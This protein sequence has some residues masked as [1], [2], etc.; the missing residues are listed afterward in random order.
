MDAARGH[1][2]LRHLFPGMVV[3]LAIVATGCGEDPAQG[4]D[5]VVTSAQRDG[6]VVTLS[7]ST[8]HVVAGDPIKL[9]VD[10]LNAGL[11]IVSWQ[12][13][14]CELLN[15][16]GIEGRQIT[17]P[18]D[19]R[20]WP[21]G[22]GLA[23]WSATTGGVALAGIQL[24]SSQD[25][26]LAAC[27]ADLRYEDIGP[28]E[29]ISADAVWSGQSTDGVPAPPG[30]YQLVYAFPFIG[31]VPAAQLGGATPPV[32]PIGV[33]LPIVL[34]GTAFSGLPSTLAIDAALGDPRVAA[35]SDAHLP[36]ERL[37]GAEIRL[38]DGRWRFTIR[39]DGDRSTV[40]IVDPATGN[41]DDV[42]LA[43]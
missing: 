26:A 40:V 9:R 14:G 3:V 6:V 11:D 19:G 7:A 17:Q 30:A 37:N 24:P 1:T 38:V 33:G 5:A 2:H 32:R 15:G 27:P 29:T 16:F 42:H 41:V 34:D 22:A 35:W 23:K 20:E 12:S 18:P 31:R 43:D 10:V 28:R 36:K 21:G 13:G 4:A 25:A 8:D 39:V